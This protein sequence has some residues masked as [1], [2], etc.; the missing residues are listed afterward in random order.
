MGSPLALHPPL[1]HVEIRVSNSKLDRSWNA[2]C[3][4]C[5]YFKSL[6][7]CFHLPLNVTLK[8]FTCFSFSSS[9]LMS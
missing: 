6:K 1:K 2:I 9:Q 7:C 4:N 3:T 8:G 5:K